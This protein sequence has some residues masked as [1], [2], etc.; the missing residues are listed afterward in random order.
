ME[1]RVQGA[2]IGNAVDAA[3]TIADKLL[4]IHAQAAASDVPSRVCGMRETSC[5]PSSASLMGCAARD[6]CAG[7]HDETNRCLV[8]VRFS[9]LCH[10]QETLTPLTCRWSLRPMYANNCGWEYPAEAR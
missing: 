8:T 10:E 5:A 4:P 6:M 2:E 1:S 3:L 9:C 7:I